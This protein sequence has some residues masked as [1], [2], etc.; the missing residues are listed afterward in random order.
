MKTEKEVAVSLGVV[1][2]MAI[3]LVLS[4]VIY[5]PSLGS[6]PNRRVENPGKGV[7]YK[8]TLREVYGLDED[9]INEIM[10]DRPENFGNQSISIHILEEAPTPKG[11][12]AA[13][14]VTS[15]LWDYRGYDTLGEA[16]VIFI[17]VAGV[18]AL[19]RAEGKEE[20]S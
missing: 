15:V 5:A 16:T 8:N 10:K 7:T 6:F 18:A 19:F 9:D 3:V 13:N 4:V 1:L 17:A 14:V 11:T 12:K 20:E 2:I